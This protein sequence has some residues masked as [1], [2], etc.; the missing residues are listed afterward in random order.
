MARLTFVG[1][2][3]DDTDTVEAFGITFERGKAVTVPDDHPKLAKLKANQTFADTPEEVRA[4][5]EA[6]KA[7]DK[8]AKAA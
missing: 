5:K 8:A 3:G 2:P 1:T 4:A 6:D 7:A